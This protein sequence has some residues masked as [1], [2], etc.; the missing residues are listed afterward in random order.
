MLYKFI[1]R[2]NASN[3][4]QSTKHNNINS[5]KLTHLSGRNKE[6]WLL[7]WHYYDYSSA[8]ADCGQKRSSLRIGPLINKQHTSAY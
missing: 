2:T 5:D 6:S 1:A 3:A 4:L 7:D 8:R